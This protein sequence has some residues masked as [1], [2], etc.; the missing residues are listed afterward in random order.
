MTNEAEFLARNN[1]FFAANKSREKIERPIFTD[2]QLEI[3]DLIAEKLS[4]RQIAKKLKCSEGNI[5]HIRK[6]IRELIGLNRE[7]SLE[8]WLKENGW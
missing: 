4:I 8:K 3:M 7:E 1:P 2:R 6:H 5:G